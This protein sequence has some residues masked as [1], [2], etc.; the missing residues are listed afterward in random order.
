[1]IFLRIT[2]S[3]SST[4]EELCQL[5]IWRVFPLP[6][7]VGAG[8]IYVGQDG[9][10]FILC[11]AV[12]L[13]RL[14]PFS[15]LLTLVSDFNKP[16][17]FFCP[18]VQSDYRLLV[19]W[20]LVI[21]EKL[22]GFPLVERNHCPFQTGRPQGTVSVT[23]DGLDKLSV[24]SPPETLIPQ[25]CFLWVNVVVSWTCHKQCQVHQS[26][27]GF[28]CPAGVSHDCCPMCVRGVLWESMDSEVPG[29]WGSARF[30][31][32]QVLCRL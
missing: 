13:S 30:S 2:Q 21:K 16:W 23:Q 6:L 5:L 3:L 26:H 17:I 10:C 27:L 22:Q 15:R 12:P 29:K 28:L 19:S 14:R 20:L 4:S 11:S 18:C 31:R 32:A 8:S 9:S 24:H 7:L 1:M 25:V